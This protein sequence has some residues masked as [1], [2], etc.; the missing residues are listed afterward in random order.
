MVEPQVNDTN[1]DEVTAG[2]APIQ[3]R[4]CGKLS[5]MDDSLTSLLDKFC[6][7]MFGMFLRQRNPCC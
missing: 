3:G 2:I 1:Y 5:S 4:T 6:H 7:W